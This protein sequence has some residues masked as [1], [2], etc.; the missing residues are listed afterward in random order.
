V[1]HPTRSATRRLTIAATALLTGLLAAGCTDDGDPAAEPTPTATESP[2]ESA[3]PTASE[4]PTATPTPEPGGTTKLTTRGL[5]QGAPPAVAYAAAVDPADPSGPW[6]LVRADGS[7]IAHRVTGD[8]GAFA[9]MGRG[10]VLLDDEGSGPLVTVVDGAGHEVRSA[11]SR[12]YSLAVT[13]D[14]SIVGWLGA[15]GAPQ[16]IEG[17][18]KRSWDLPV[19][20]RG[21]ELGAIL[22]QRTC[23][24]QSPEGG[25]CTAFVNSGDASRSYLSTSHGIVDV[26]GRMRSIVDVDAAGRVIGLVS[27]ADDGSCSGLWRNSFRKPRWQT[28]DYT[29]TSFSPDGAQLL[30]TDPYLDGLGQRTLAFLDQDGELVHEFSSGRNGPIITQMVWEDDTHALA[31]VLDRTDWAVLRL[32]TDGSAEYAVAAVRGTDTERPFGLPAD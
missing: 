1:R 8:V 27:I 22:G 10:M 20:R 23:K 6:E 12:G 21:A 13:P 31:L 18:G 3:S 9:P 25:G 5:A 32:G 16:V 26:A 14:G 19:V 24:E 28:C 4:T 29:L 15:N 2:T 17:G 11:R 7:T 30:A